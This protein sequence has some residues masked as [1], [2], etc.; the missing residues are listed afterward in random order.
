MRTD[1]QIP[2]KLAYSPAAAAQVAGL[3]K[4]TIYALIKAGH[5]KAKKSGKRTLIL[6]QDLVDYLVNLDGFRT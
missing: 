4:T 6:R 2:D 3:C 5:L 1:L